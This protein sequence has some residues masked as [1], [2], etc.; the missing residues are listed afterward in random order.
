M[1]EIRVSTLDTGSHINAGPEPLP[2]A[3]AQRAVGGQVQRF[4][5]CGVSSGE[6]PRGSGRRLSPVL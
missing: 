6:R 4:V 2:E 3:R 1:E 5:R